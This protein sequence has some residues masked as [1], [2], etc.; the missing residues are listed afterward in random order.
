ML[1]C[2]AAGS[3]NAAP[4]SPRTAITAL[5]FIEASFRVVKSHP[6]RTSDT[7]KTGFSTA[8]PGRNATCR[9]R[10]MLRN[11][12]ETLA[13]RQVLER[14]ADRF[15]KGQIGRH[16]CHGRERFLFVVAERHERLHDLR[17]PAAL[18]R[19]RRLADAAF[20]LEQQALGGFLADP[21]DL[22]EPRRILQRHAIRELAHRHA[23]EHRE[24]GARADAGNAD[25][26]PKDAALLSRG[27]AVEVVRVLTHD[28]VREEAYR[29]AIGGQR[30]ERAHR[31]V[32][33]VGFAADIDEHLRRMLRREPPG[34]SADQMSLPLRMRSPRVAR[35]PN[36]APCAWQIAQASA[37]A[38]SGEGSPGSA[39]SRRTMCCTCSF[40]A[41]PLPTTDCFTC[42]AV[43]SDTGRPAITAAQ[44]AVPRAWPRSSVDW[45]F[46]FTKTFSTAT[47]TGPC[48][49]I[50]SRSPSRM[51]FSR[52]ARSP[53]PDLTQ[54]LVM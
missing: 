33:L 16:I 39:S 53:L 8:F 54:P 31:H 52:V 15:G 37:S 13:T 21:R 46:T 48:C 51:V 11:C 6:L 34:E 44:I 50:T 2:A 45:G 10:G 47:S 12:N 18:R 30:V 25:Q 32:E 14:C 41:W 49:A 28:E 42:S 9:A 43:Y 4:A 5:V 24:R 19:R 40:A 29:L 35:R 36:C 20:E 26:L 27:E 3:A 23:G 22:G 38:A 17:S 1:I 7:N